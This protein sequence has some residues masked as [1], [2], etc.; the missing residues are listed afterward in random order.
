MFNVNDVYPDLTG[1]RFL[2]NCL[3]NSEDDA[4]YIEASFLMSV[5]EVFF[6]ADLY[7]KGNVLILDTP[8]KES[9]VKLA[10]MLNNAISKMKQ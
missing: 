4:K 10:L 8:D 3:C 6:F 5:R 7:T 9:T 1:K 2:C